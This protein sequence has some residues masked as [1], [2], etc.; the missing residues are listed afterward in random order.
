MLT[1]QGETAG[2]YSDLGPGATVQTG[3]KDPATVAASLFGIGRLVWRLPALLAQGAAAA[4]A[5]GDCTNEVTATGEA[6]DD[7]VTLYR[8]VRPEELNDLLRFGDYGLSPSGAG[9]YFAL[10]EQGVRDFIQ[11][12]LN[13]DVDMVLTKI[14]VPISFVR[15]FG[16]LF[17]DPGT[18]GAKD[19]VHFADDVLPYLYEIMKGLPQIILD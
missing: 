19:S 18:Y 17:H 15:R 6:I 14:E 8:A 10:T 1:A 7:T 2:S 12:P 3:L 13:A 5:D 4:C 9:K 16:F 11:S